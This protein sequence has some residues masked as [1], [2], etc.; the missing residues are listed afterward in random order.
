MWSFWSHWFLLRH[1]WK[2]WSIWP[3]FPTATEEF[4]F[5]RS[6]CMDFLPPSGGVFR[7]SFSGSS[8]GISYRRSCGFQ[9]PTGKTATKKPSQNRPAL[10]SLFL[11]GH[12]S[13]LCKRLKAKMFS[14][15]GPERIC[16]NMLYSIVG[17]DYHKNRAVSTKS[18]ENTPI[19]AGCKKNRWK[20]WQKKR[21][22][23]GTSPLDKVR[24]VPISHNYALYASI[25]RITIITRCWAWS[26]DSARISLWSLA[27]L[28]SSSL[29]KKYELWHSS[30]NHLIDF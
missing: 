27:S 9:G 23:D 8:P 11:E 30:D 25:K 13:R 17:I 22:L 4:A 14:P 24:I 21:E 19:S 1:G 29:A 5:C 10:P 20:L 26:S 3:H 15:A 12:A 7:L 18:F 6:P 28:K 16:K 2:M